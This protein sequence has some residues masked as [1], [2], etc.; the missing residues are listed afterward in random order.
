L[1]RRSQKKLRE[2]QAVGRDYH[3]VSMRAIDAGHYLGGLERGRLEDGKS[4][5]LCESLD[6]ARRVVLTSSRRS[7]GLGEDQ[8][9]L[10]ARAMQC[11]K[12]ALCELGRP[13]ED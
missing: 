3:G 13:G 5:L 10:V 4:M 6:G 9:D 2:D 12:R 1:R 7:V 11:N 8:S